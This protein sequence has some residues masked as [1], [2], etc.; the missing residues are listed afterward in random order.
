DAGS[1]AAVQA[2]IDRQKAL[3]HQEIATLLGDRLAARQALLP[4]LTKGK[5]DLDAV[6]NWCAAQP[7][8]ASSPSGKE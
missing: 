2:R 3:G 5:T 8:P 6:K 1:I 4:I 7:K